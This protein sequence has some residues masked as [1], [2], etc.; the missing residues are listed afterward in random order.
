MSGAISNIAVNS[1]LK[2]T[3]ERVYVHTSH[4]DAILLVAVPMFDIDIV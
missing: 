1:N 2:V 3:G 4:H